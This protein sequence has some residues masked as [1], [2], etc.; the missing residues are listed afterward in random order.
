ML[1]ASHAATPLPNGKLLLDQLENLIKTHSIAIRTHSNAPIA[2]NSAEQAAA[3][4]EEPPNFV[5]HASMQEEFIDAAA[6]ARDVTAHANRLEDLFMNARFQA[7][8]LKRT[9]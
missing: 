5:P 9:D 4:A 3:L 7:L 6:L 8:I 2:G 1:E